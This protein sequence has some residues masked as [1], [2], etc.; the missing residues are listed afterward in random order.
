MVQLLTWII[1]NFQ[2]NNLVSLQYSSELVHKHFVRPDRIPGKSPRSTG[3]CKASPVFANNLISN[4][5]KHN[6]LHYNTDIAFINQG[7]FLTI[8]VL[9]KGDFQLH[10]KE[11]HI[12]AQPEQ[13]HSP[14]S[15]LS[16]TWMMCLH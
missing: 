6:S 4:I 5:N 10:G 13:G 14:V 7:T 11:G 9:K 15:R 3:K 2:F 1:L 16:F 12:G 8:M